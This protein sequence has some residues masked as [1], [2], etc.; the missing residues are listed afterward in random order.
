MIKEELKEIFL[1]AHAGPFLFVGSGFSRRYLGLEDWGGLLSKFCD[2]LRPFEYYLSKAN[3]QVPMV[4]TLMSADFNEYWWSSEAYEASRTKNKGKIKDQTSALRVEICEYLKSASV[5][6]YKDSEYSE[7]LNLIS[8]LNVDGIITTNWD[9]LL[10]EL[11]PDYKVYI[12]QQ[13]LLFSNPQSIGEIYKIHG[14][15]SRSKS[16]VLTDEDYIDFN[17]RNA[18]LAAKLITIFVEHPIIFIGYSV[19]DQNIASLLLSIA[20]C[21]GERAAEQLKNNLIFVQRLKEGEKEGLS[22]TFLTIDG[23]RIPIIVVKSETFS[24]VYEAIHETKRK[25][26]ARVLRYC[27]EQLY[28]IVKTQSPEEKICV[29]DIDQVENKDDIEFVVGVGVVKERAEQDQEEVGQYGYQGIKSIDLFTDLL[30]NNGGFDAKR[31][32]EYTIP[33]IGKGSS[34]IPVYKY[35]S[36]AGIASQA[37]YERSGYDLSKWLNRKDD[38]FHTKTH[39]RS[40]VKNHKESTAQ[41]IVDSCTP[42]NAAIFLSFLKPDKFDASVVRQFLDEHID[43]FDYKVCSGSSYF[44]KLSC[45]YD[46]TVYGW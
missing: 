34:Y 15:S 29:V 41:E 40:F 38:A 10:E 24:S 3:G 37:D 12:G 22:E 46:Q 20:K 25:I 4:A 30:R 45:Y 35:L 43:K 33:S 39:A 23:V 13:E 14:C 6:K 7:E 32:I 5:G 18:Y 27:K 2:G 31:I 17:D 11:F 26:P 9:R 44:R 42:E 28:E 21:I 19:S 8:Q 36:E 1:Q 16:L